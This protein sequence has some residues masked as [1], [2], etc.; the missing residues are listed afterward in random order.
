MLLRHHRSSFSPRRPTLCVCVYRRVYVYLSPACLPSR[1]PHVSVSTPDPFPWPPFPRTHALLPQAVPMSR[2]GAPCTCTLCSL[3]W[4]WVSPARGQMPSLPCSAPAILQRTGRSSL[5][6]GSVPPQPEASVGSVST[7]GQAAPQCG[8]SSS[9]LG[10]GPSAVETLHT[11]PGLCVPSARPPLRSEGACCA[12]GAP[13]PACP[14]ALPRGR[15][16]LP[17][18]GSRSLP[19]GQVT[20]LPLPAQP[21][22][23]HCAHAPISR[24]GGGGP[25]RLRRGCAP[26]FAWTPRL[27]QA[28][29]LPVASGARMP[30][31]GPLCFLLSSLC[32]A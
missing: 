21:T 18:R 3:S 7:A 19:A 32:P 4:A 5:W 26:P 8:R 10:S 23:L 25:R 1:R 13:K 12:R 30:W 6:S 9:C 20:W 16:P 29:L 22:P 24:G 14:A 11:S 31:F 17:A 15:P 2:A 28:A 27:C